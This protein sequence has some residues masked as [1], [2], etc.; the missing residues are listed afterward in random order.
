MLRVYFLLC[1]VTAAAAVTVHPQILRIPLSRLTA[2]ARQVARSSGLEAPAP[3]TWDDAA[4]V[5]LNNYMDAQYYGEI[6]IGTPGQSFKV[7]FDTG[8]SNLWVPSKKCSLLD[9]A[10]KLHNKYDSSKSSSYD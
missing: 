9:V 3:Y 2:T 8:S 6:Q 10:C 5:P 7:C 4:N 1:A